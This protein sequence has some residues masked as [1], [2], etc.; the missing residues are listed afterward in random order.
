[1]TTYILQFYQFIKVLIQ[2]FW[3]SISSASF[4]GNVYRNY[5]GYGIKY[6]L[7]LSFICIFFV[8]IF[9][10]NYVDNIAVYLRDGN[11]DS[12]VAQRLDHILTQIPLLKYDGKSLTVADDDFNSDVY[13]MNHKKVIA[14]DTEEKFSSAS[15]MQTAI[16]LRKNNFYINIL[17]PQGQLLEHFVIAYDKVLGKQEAVLDQ[18]H[19]R[20]LLLNF[21]N[22]VYKPIIYVL[23]PILSF[24]L[25]VSVIFEKILLILI[26]FIFSKLRR[27]GGLKNSIRVVFF[28][29]GFFILFASISNFLPDQVEQAMYL[30]QIWI[31]LLLFFG[32]FMPRFSFKVIK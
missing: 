1:M 4:Y 20:R 18:S 31:N 25:L 21:A 24:L 10:L 14:I 32:I 16:V 30:G 28:S 6:I 9:L 12:V 22:I 15:M 11:S 7:N 26:I 5:N 13:S 23:F 29:S 27:S 8:S 17:S 3:L 19:M 2:H